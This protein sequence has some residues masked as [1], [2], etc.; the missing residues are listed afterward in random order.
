[1]KTGEYFDVELGV[2][3]SVGAFPEGIHRAKC[4]DARVEPNKA[5][6]SH[7]LILDFEAE[8][9]EYSGRRVRTWLSFKDSVRWKLTEALNAFGVETEVGSD[10]KPKVHITRKSFVGNSVR[11][12]VVHE[13]YMGEARPNV[14]QILDLRDAEKTVKEKQAAPQQTSEAPASQTANDAVNDIDIE[15][16]L[17]F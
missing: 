3:T 10:G 1:M 9:G 4:V 12:H 13:D 16:D 7:N 5:G 15:E 14:N 2:D 17:P 8:G 11:L 6:D